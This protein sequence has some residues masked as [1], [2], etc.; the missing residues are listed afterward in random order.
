MQD[1]RK[2]K[3][4]RAPN[5]D[6]DP[7][8]TVIIG[9]LAQLAWSFS[10]EEVARQLGLAVDAADERF[11]RNLRRAAREGMQAIARGE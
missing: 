1:L 2:L 8:M 3:E 11:I 7:E 5:A 9:W 6:L 4:E 10:R